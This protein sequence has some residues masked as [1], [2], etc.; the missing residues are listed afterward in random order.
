MDNEKYFGL[1][2]DNAQCN[3]R[4]Y[5]PDPLTTPS[6]VKYKKKK[7]ILPKLLVWMVMSSKCVSNIYVHKSEQAITS[8]N[9]PP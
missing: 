3:Q 9:P 8:G 2:G 4:Y 7:E 5:T 1:S 6:D